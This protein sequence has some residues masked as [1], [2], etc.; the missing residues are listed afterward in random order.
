MVVKRYYLGL[1]RMSFRLWLQFFYD[2]KLYILSL[3]FL[4]F[5]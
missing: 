4:A 2:Y 1:M 3:L 5:A